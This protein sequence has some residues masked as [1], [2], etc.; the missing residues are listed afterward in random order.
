VASAP[1]QGNATVV[2]SNCPGSGTGYG[3]DTGAV[4][5]QVQA[6]GRWQLRVDEEV[7]SPLNEPPLTAMSASGSAV[8]FSGSFYGIDKQAQG[9]FRLYQLANGG[10]ALR[11]QDFYVTP[12]TDLEIRLSTAPRLRTTSDYLRSSSAFVAALPITAGSMNFVV[13]VGVNPHVYQSV[14]IWCQRQVSAY[15]AAPLRT[16]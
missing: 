15:A 13:P 12:N 1:A 16:P 2:R 6:T 5:L 11:F 4:T 3:V 10:Y 9:R 8:L 14:V 7:N